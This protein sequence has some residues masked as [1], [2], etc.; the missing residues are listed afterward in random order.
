[1]AGLFQLSQPSGS[2]PMSLLAVAGCFA[3]HFST[4]ILLLSTLF[5]V[6]T[7]NKEK[8]VP[9]GVIAGA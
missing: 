2:V 6:R 7:G 5:T 3:Q 1:M 9:L 8:G 4:V